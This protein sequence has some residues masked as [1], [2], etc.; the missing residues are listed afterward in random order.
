MYKEDGKTRKE[1]ALETKNHLYAVADALFTQYGF[2]YVSVDKIVEEAGLSKGTF[3]V[4][5]ESK[6][7]LLV[8]LIS[9]YVDKVDVDYQAFIEIFSSDMPATDILLRLIDKIMD[10]IVDTIGHKRMKALYRAQL[11]NISHTGTS[12]SY[13]RM[14]YTTITDVLTRGIQRREIVTALPLSELTNHVILAMR[15]LTYEWCIRYP[16]FD[17]KAQSRAHFEIILQGI[18]G[19][20]G[21]GQGQQQSQ[22]SQQ[23]QP[24]QN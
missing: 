16:D 5:F 22:Q 18:K 2:D 23:S 11:T 21:S 19:D 7:S 4:H 24:S 8:A 10:V 17:L 9:D 15:G 12:A 6:D 13:N 20:H 1:R 3:Y 14:L